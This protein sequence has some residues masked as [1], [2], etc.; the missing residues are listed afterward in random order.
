MS[1]AE[2]A[3]RVRSGGIRLMQPVLGP[4]VPCHLDRF[5]RNRRT[6]MQAYRMP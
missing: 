4:K 6:G 2:L 1:H 5:T 3:G